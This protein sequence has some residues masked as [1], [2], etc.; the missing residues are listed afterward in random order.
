MQD[1]H[2]EGDAVA[3]GL[4]VGTTEA[5]AWFGAPGPG[6]GHRARPRQVT[7]VIIVRTLTKVEF[8]GFAYALAIAAAG[9]ILLSPDQRRLLSRF[10]ATDEEQHDYARMFG[11][12]FLAVDTIFVT[13]VLG[14]GIPFLFSDRLI[15]PSSKVTRQ[16]ALCSS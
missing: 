2:L 12:M 8:G 4:G 6:A 1:R 5:I 11:A 14:I 16:W 3:A 13:S 10:M 9:R 7:Q 15:G